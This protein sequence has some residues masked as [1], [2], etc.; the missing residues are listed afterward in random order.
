MF[1]RKNIHPVKNGLNSPYC[2]HKATM[3]T[4]LHVVILLVDISEGTQTD[5]TGKITGHCLVEQNR[6]REMYSPV[7]DESH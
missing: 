4:K 1:G 5:S 2:G 3:N 6:S 7:Y